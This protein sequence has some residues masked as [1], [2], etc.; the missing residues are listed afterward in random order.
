[1]KFSEQM[2]FPYPVLWSNTDD[3]VSGEFE[4]TVGE[5]RER[6]DTGSVAIDLTI[7]LEQKEIA[8]LLASGA[9]K[10]G[11]FVTCLSTYYNTLVELPVGGGRLDMRPG[12]LKGDVR[13]RAVVWSTSPVASFSS[14]DLHPEYGADTFTFPAST[15]IAVGEEI[16]IDVGRDKLA[17]VASIFL[18]S[19]ND[20]IPPD[21]IRVD[22]ESDRINVMAASATY[23]KLHALRGTREGQ[24]VLLNSI[25]L[26]AVMNVLSALSGDRARHEGKRWYEVVTAKAVHLGLDI[27][28]AEPLD[29]A[30]R[31]LMS[32]FKRISA[33]LS[34]RSL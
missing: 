18:L 23:D 12:L 19:R 22:L 10:S 14:S 9:A 15:I 13:L 30:Q 5:I 26:P 6:L 3:Y 21:E 29:G 17:P 7:G 31:L 24:A 32:P 27:D 11:V 33:E 28:N 20:E 4:T 25:Y 8:S 2:R 1:V 16:V 34:L